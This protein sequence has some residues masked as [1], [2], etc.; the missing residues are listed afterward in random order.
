MAALV[1]S[2]VLRLALV[3]RLELKFAVALESYPTLVPSSALGL[4]PELEVDFDHQDL[5]WQQNWVPSLMPQR[6]DSLQLCRYHS[7]QE[8]MLPSVG[9]VVSL[10]AWHAWGI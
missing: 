8:A 10:Q 9:S 1:L 6:P 7:V 2:L 3:L 4:E 5:A